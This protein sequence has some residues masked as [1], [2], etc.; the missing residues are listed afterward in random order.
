MVAYNN[1]PPYN[2]ISINVAP[3]YF[4]PFFAAALLASFGGRPRPRF[5]PSGLGFY[6]KSMYNIRIWQK[7]VESTLNLVV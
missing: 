4:L 1:Q 5:G 7:K 3:V 2:V 6:K